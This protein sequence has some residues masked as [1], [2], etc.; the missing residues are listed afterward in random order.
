MPTPDLDD[1]GFIRV[2]ATAEPDLWLRC[3][4]CGKS[5]HFLLADKVACLCGA[6]YDHARTPGGEEVGLDRLTFVRF[7]EGPLRLADL[8][9]D[10]RKLAGWLLLA[11]LAA[12]ALWW[13]ST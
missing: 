5:D 11:V 12:V 7:T 4:Q 13:A 10:P 6:T 8:E 3:D 2:K 1:R 9:L